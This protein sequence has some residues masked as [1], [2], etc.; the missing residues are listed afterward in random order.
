V[1]TGTEPLTA[2]DLLPHKGKMLLIDDIVELSEEAATSRSRVRE[3]WPLVVGQAA[4]VLLI[5]ELVAQTSGLSNGLALVNHNGKNTN[6]KGWVVG[7][8]TAR[9]YVD[10]LP[11]GAHIVTR[12]VNLFKFDEFVEIKGDARIDD[13]IVGEV[14]LQVMKA[15]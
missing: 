10:S 5:V 14:V 11:V 15:G 9:F 7:I 12:A 8:K 6:K 1:S 3:T 2:E 4:G 13:A